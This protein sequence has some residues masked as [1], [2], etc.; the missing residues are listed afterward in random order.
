MGKTATIILAAGQG[1][2]FGGDTPKQFLR[3]NGKA[4]WRLSLEA[5]L[6]FSDEIV[7]VTDEN[8]LEMVSKEGDGFFVTP[9]GKS[10][11]ESVL[12]GLRFLNTLPDKPETVLIHDAARCLVTPEIIEA[13]LQKAR[14]SGAAITAVPATDTVKTVDRPAGAEG[15]FP[16]TTDTPDRR[17]L[18]QAQT[19][20]GFDFDLI[21]SAYEKADEA[22]GLASLTDD[23]SAVE[24]F[25][26][27]PVLVTPGSPENIKVTRPLDLQFAESILRFRILR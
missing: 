4:L 26:D 10:R 22:G 13:C 15:D 23:A 2:R 27:H 6:P 12:F 3:L 17:F 11:A 25:T 14:E 8:H 21:L 5:F 1:T 18:Y 19:P 16:V 7:V 24:R 9:G 20:Q